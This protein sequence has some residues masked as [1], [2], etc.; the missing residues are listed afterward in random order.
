MNAMGSTGPATTKGG[1]PAPMGASSAMGGGT[2]ATRW[3]KEAF[4]RGVKCCGFSDNVKYDTLF[5]MVLLG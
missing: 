5:S 4:T 3:V 2:N 1:Y